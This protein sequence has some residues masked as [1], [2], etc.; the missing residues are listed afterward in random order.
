MFCTASFSFSQRLRKLSFAKITPPLLRTILAPVS[1]ASFS[2][3]AP[4]SLAWPELTHFSMGEL[5]LN[6]MEDD[7]ICM[8]INGLML[9]VGRAISYMPRIQHLDMAMSY[10]HREQLNNVPTYTPG[11]TKIAFDLQSSQDSHGHVPMG[12]LS[13]T[14]YMDSDVPEAVPSRGVVE[15]WEKSLS[16]A[17]NAILEVHVVSRPY[18]ECQALGFGESEIEWY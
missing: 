3:Y 15:L 13:V 8:V 6:E 4:P 12:N 16:Y 7:E 5:D 17:A 9:T 2:S 18:I 10:L 11:S 1:T 14:H